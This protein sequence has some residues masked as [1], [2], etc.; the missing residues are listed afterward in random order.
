MREKKEC[1]NR[2]L[3]LK[4]YHYLAISVAISVFAHL[5][6]LVFLSKT[7]FSE[8]AISPVFNVDLVAPSEAERY[9]P[10]D[11]IPPRVIKKTVKDAPLKYSEPSKSVPSV[12]PETMFGYGDSSRVP[13]NIAE[14]AAGDKAEAVSDSRSTAVDNS[15][16][17]GEEGFSL[18][19]ESSQYDRAKIVKRG[20]GLSSE[21]NVISIDTSDLKFRGYMRSLKEKIEG[22]WQYPEKAKKLGISGDLNMRFVIKRDGTLGEIDIIRPS[23]YVELDKAAMKAVKDASPFWPLPADWEGD[24]YA[25]DGHFIYDMRGPYVW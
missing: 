24:D 14:S 13:E 19:L 10:E 11:I 25:I 1:S 15:R 4:H 12:D 21:R 7:Y 18:L 23:G 16:Q 20:E 2:A 3:E 17:T 22:I 5:I 9:V 8:E 6:L